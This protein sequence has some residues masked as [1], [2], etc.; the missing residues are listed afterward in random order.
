MVGVLMTGEEEGATD[1]CPNM[2]RAL[3]ETH[4]L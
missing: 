1:A 2:H 3:Y 4:P